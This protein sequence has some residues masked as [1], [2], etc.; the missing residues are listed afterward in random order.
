[1]D[2]TA[3]LQDSKSKQFRNVQQAPC[4]ANKQTLLVIFIEPGRVL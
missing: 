1:M 2:H 4:C 3:E